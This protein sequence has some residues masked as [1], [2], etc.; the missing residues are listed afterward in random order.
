MKKN[1]LISIAFF[2]LLSQTVFSRDWEEIEPTLINDN[3]VFNFDL[4]TDDYNAKAIDDVGDYI[5]RDITINYTCEIK[6]LRF[7][8]PHPHSE[9][10]TY[11]RVWIRF[12]YDHESGESIPIYSHSFSSGD[13]DVNL[14]GTIIIPH[15]IETG[16][17]EYFGANRF[18]LEMVRSYCDYE[19]CVLNQQINSKKFDYYLLNDTADKFYADNLDQ[20]IQL[21][22]QLKQSNILAKWAQTTGYNTIT[23]GMVM[24]EGFDPQNNN[25][26]AWYY[27]AGKDLL[28]ECR[29]R[30]R[31]VYILDFAE[32]GNTIATSKNT[33]DDCAYIISA[34]EYED[35]VEYGNASVVQDAT[36]FISS[37][38]H[39][40]RSVVL[41]GTSMGGVVSRYALAAA[42]QVGQ[43]LPVSHFLSIDSP[44]QYATID[45][46]LM[47]FVYTQPKKDIVLENSYDYNDLPYGERPSIL[48]YRATLE[49][50]WNNPASHYYV[51]GEYKTESISRPSKEHLIFYKQLNELNGEHKGYPSNCR[52]LGVAF[53]KFHGFNEVS[54]GYTWLELNIAAAGK[55][56]FDYTFGS[57]SEDFSF[58]QST[59]IGG[60]ALNKRTLFTGSK[61]PLSYTNTD[62]FSSN[63]NLN[64]S[65]LCNMLSFDADYVIAITTQTLDQPTFIPFASALDLYNQDS[66]LLYPFS[67]YLVDGF[68]LDDTDN[69]FYF[70]FMDENYFTDVGAGTIP[71]NEYKKVR[72][73]FDQIA[74]LNRNGNHDEFPEEITNPVLD[75]IED[76]VTED[77]STWNNTWKNRAVLTKDI[78]IES[79]NTLYIE[80]GINNSI[81]IENDHGMFEIV[82]TILVKEGAEVVIEDDTTLY[83][84]DSAYFVFE[85]GSTLTLGDNCVINLGNMSHFVINEGVTFNKG[86]SYK[87]ESG[88]SALF[89]WK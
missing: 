1:I 86:E 76:K 78:N 59:A 49:L 57:F 79:G 18:C 56:E 61:L 8:S 13:D 55:F 50:L 34:G 51:G 83:L 45:Y 39:S 27:N 88:P 58:N 74:F 77:I 29:S 35:I 4:S 66:G 23:T 75:F 2:V 33:I 3:L 30:N 89:N 64:S 87:I 21:V 25:F 41:A 44:Q 40:R 28:D 71:Y 48:S 31:D 5:A 7:T 68:Y 9:V 62:V 69:S 54:Q 11:P 70:S 42:E 26:P 60:T 43:T 24:V 17:R 73:R 14:S 81:K 22:D 72:S 32:G 10:N 63:D 67:K 46:Q 65:M 47:D 80:N 36:R 16:S 19:G 20:S 53:S 38:L 6:N 15:S 52:N 12:Y 85:Q 37:T 84:T 82:T